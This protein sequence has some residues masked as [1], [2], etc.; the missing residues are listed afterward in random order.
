[1]YL[2]RNT[3]FLIFYFKKT[4]NKNTSCDFQ[5][6]KWLRYCYIKKSVSQKLY[7]L[8]SILICITE[9]LMEYT[10]T[11]KSVPRTNLNKAAAVAEEPFVE[12]ASTANHFTAV[13]SIVSRCIY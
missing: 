11:V 3:N 10:T 1:M 7:V 13:F 6:L 2:I 5:N 9:E 4:K 12:F 8:T